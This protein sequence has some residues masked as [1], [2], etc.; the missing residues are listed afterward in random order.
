MDSV[1]VLDNSPSAVFSMK[2]ATVR[3]HGGVEWPLPRPRS[4][5]PCIHRWPHLPHL[6]VAIISFCFVAELII[7]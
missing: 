7:Q 1:V 3:G 6:T 2:A 5:A 4:S